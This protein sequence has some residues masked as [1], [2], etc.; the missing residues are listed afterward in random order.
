MKANR[1]ITDEEAVAA[2]DKDMEERANRAK[3][4]LSQRY[5]GLKRQQVRIL[6][7]WL[8]CTR[9]LS[10][11]TNSN[12]TLSFRISVNR[13]GAKLVK[14]NWSVRCKVWEFQKTRERKCARI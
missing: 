6:L 1:P 5:V 3:E 4:L 7:S 11:L 9:S 14:C 10:W 8:Y 13:K 2:A 12:L